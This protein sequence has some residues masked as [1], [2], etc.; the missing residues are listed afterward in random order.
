MY[1]S[2]ILA[3]RVFL[4]LLVKEDLLDLE[5][6]KETGGTL[7]HQDLKAFRDQK[8]SNK[9]T[10][11]GLLGILNLINFRINVVVVIIAI[12]IIKKLTKL[13]GLVF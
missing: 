4:G 12:I 10:C 8:V 5:G 1:I 11:T 13:H 2:L 7:V 6:I 9:F 3:C